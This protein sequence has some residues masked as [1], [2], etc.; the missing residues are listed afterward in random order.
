[1][2]WLVEQ[3]YC[4]LGVELLELVI[5]QFFSEYQL[6]LVVY[7]SV[8]GCYYV[9]GQIELICGDIFVLDDVILVNCVGVYD[10]VVFIV[11]F[12]DMCVCYV[13]EIYGRLLVQVC[14]FLI[15]LEY[16]QEKME[17]LFFLVVEEE[18]LCF[19]VLYS[20]VV[21]ID[22]CDILEKEFKFFECGLWVLDMVV[23]CLQCKG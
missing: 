11:L 10:C 21:V 9:V 22:W 20:E 18:V 8:Q 15:M 5:I 6:I 7:E 19:Y 14:S 23:Y 4:V 1:M 13:E 17:G 16:D 2:L 12:L 3:G